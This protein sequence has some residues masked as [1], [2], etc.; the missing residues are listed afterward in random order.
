MRVSF[1]VH[2]LFISL[3]LVCVNGCSRKTDPQVRLLRDAQADALKAR[4]LLTELRAGRMTNA[5]ELLEQE[6]DVSIVTIDKFRTNVSDSDQSNALATLRTLKAY[7]E[8][9]PRRREAVI[10]DTTPF[11]QETEDLRQNASNILSRIR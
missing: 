9:H 11:A 8:E 6:L 10:P 5:E 1:L 7:R 3:L 4:I 2:S